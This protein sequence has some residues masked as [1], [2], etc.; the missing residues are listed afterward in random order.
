M[1]TFQY[2]VVY[3]VAN[4]LLYVLILL[5]V[6]YNCESKLSRWKTLLVDVVS[7][8]GYA[9]INWAL[10]VMSAIRTVGGL[11]YLIVVVQL[12]H[13]GSVLFKLVATFAAYLSM[14][15]SDIVYMAM[16]PRDMAVTGELMQK[17]PVPVYGALLFINLVF[18]SITAVLLRILRKRKGGF[19]AG[20]SSLLF[21]LFPISQFVTILTYF[22]MYKN[23]DVPMN[24]WEIF[25]SII[26]FLLADIALM[27]AFR[28][29][30]RNTEMKVRNEIL[31]EQISFQKDYYSEL[32][33][34]Y[35]E[36]RKMRHDIDNHVYTM[37]AMMDAGRTEEAAAYVREL[38]SQDPA[39]KTFA[40]CANM[41]A[42]SYLTKKMEDYKRLGIELD[43]DI[44]LPVETGITNPDLICVFG[45]ILDNAQE[46]CEGLKDPKVEL[47]AQYQ[48]PY[49]SVSCVNPVREE[50]KERSA[51]KTR[52]PGL[53]RGIGLT[54]LEDLANRYD[55]QLET[56]VTENGFR[57][58]VV[59]KG[60]E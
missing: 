34:S 59:L 54:I 17:Y 12:L 39:K 21:L 55:G 7:F 41:V 18:F 37:R 47:K 46:A 8:A 3:T 26:I 53:E 58:R 14:L 43:A 29:A 36:I 4:W 11:V 31:E 2:T 45:N 42:A 56:G 30:D 5:T 9:A 48:K 38:A 19:A 28:T 24:P 27:F 57:T 52:I 16:M 32:S 10:P 6:Q 15:F 60:K 44:H 33:A 25:P 51:R 23:L 50:G 1:E 13:K 35:E 22:A 40:S 20:R 49:L